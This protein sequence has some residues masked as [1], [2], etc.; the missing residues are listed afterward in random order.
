MR[1]Q[2]QHWFEKENERARR[3]QA[4]RYQ[5][6]L[7]AEEAYRSDP[8]RVRRDKERSKALIAEVEA[9]LVSAFAKG[10]SIDR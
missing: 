9:E 4:L 6:L 7:E 10:S 5:M 3:E 1:A 8:E 2:I